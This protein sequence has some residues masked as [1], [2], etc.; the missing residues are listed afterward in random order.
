MGGQRVRFDIPAETR[1]V[2]ELLEEQR[3]GRLDLN[4]EFQRRS[5]WRHSEKS[6]LVDTVVRGLPIPLIILRD[7]LVV[8]ERRRI[9]EVADG[10][11]RLRTLFSFIEPAALNDF[12]EE[13]DTFAVKRSHNTDREIYGRPFDELPTQ[14]Q[15]EMLAYRLSVVFLPTTMEDRDVLDLFARLNSTGLRLTPQE[16]RNANFSGEFKSLMYRLARENLERWKRWGLFSAQEV[17]RMKD[18]ELVSDLANFVINGL[19]QKSKSE[20]DNLYEEYDESFPD[21]EEVERR[22]DH[23]LQEIDKHSSFIASSVFNREMHFVTLFA[24]LYRIAYG[25]QE[26]LRR[27]RAL[28]LKSAVWT[29]VEKASERYRSGRIPKDV[30]EASQGAAT[31]L[32]RRRARLSFLEGQISAEVER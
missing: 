17:A 29:G 28:T 26:T 14:V 13:R 21:A 3:A 24:A 4:P 2:L 31:D 25:E 23:M 5:V 16:L 9:L 22:L 8:A 15:G 27:R 10:Q 7:R 11:Q 18:V 12:D 32:K 19:R 20:L 30:A 6:Y 1:T